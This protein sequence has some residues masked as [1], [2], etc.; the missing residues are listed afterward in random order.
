MHKTIKHLDPTCSEKVK[1]LNVW[2]EHVFVEHQKFLMTLEKVCTGPIFGMEKVGRRW[3]KGEGL[4]FRA[5]SLWLRIHTG[6]LNPD[7]MQTLFHREQSTIINN[8]FI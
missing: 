8:L 5:L 3:G 7:Q 2:L 6:S 4:F 1:G